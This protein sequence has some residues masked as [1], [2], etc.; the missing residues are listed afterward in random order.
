ML[1]GVERMLRSDPRRLQI[2]GRLVGSSDLFQADRSRSAFDVPDRK[3]NPP[4]QSALQ[5]SG[6]FLKTNQ[7]RVE[8]ASAVSDGGEEASASPRIH[9]KQGPLS[10]MDATPSFCCLFVAF[11]SPFRRLFV[12]KQGALSGLCIGSGLGC[13]R[14]LELCFV[15]LLFWPQRSCPPRWREC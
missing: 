7:G 8:G 15:P 9:P 6:A 3:S 5:E 1:R 12:A 11:S 2:F 4:L 14:L 10:W 13:K